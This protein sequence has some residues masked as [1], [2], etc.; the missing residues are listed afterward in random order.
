MTAWWW[1]A[2]HN[3]LTWWAA[4]WRE[5]LLQSYISSLSICIYEYLCVYVKVSKGTNERVVYVFCYHTMR[6][7]CVSLSLSRFTIWIQFDICE[8]FVH[9]T[10][11]A[12]WKVICQKEDSFWFNRLFILQ[13]CFYKVPCLIFRRACYCKYHHK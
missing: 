5:W 13:K 3:L 9:S 8:R 4:M 1:T 2:C 7:L 11:L 10:S 6:L 12:S